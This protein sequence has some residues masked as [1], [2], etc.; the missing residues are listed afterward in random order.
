MHRGSIVGS[1]WDAPLPG[2]GSS[3]ESRRFG[4]AVEHERGANDADDPSRFYVVING[5]VDSCVHACGG[6]LYCRFKL[7]TGPDWEQQYLSNAETGLTEGV[8]QVSE[9][10]VG[11]QPVYAFNLPFS[12]SY[13]CTNP[14]GWPKFC[15]SVYSVAGNGQRSPPQGYGWCHIPTQAGHHTVE[16]PLFSPVSST[17]Q[18]W[19][20]GLIQGHTYEF[21]GT[22][23]ARDEGREV[24]RVASSGGYVKVTFSVMTKGLGSMG[25]H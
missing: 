13:A 19:F 21:K 14:W 5:T 8:T 18:S 25:Y 23:F 6:S 20:F 1:S 11:H 12:V 16:I 9:R 22:A 4:S 24:T 15:V 17:P 10:A 3:V 7:E 2:V